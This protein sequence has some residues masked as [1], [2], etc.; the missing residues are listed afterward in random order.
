MFTPNKL[1]SF[2]IDNSKNDLRFK[3]GKYFEANT[4]LLM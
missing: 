2:E 1:I 3:L 4:G